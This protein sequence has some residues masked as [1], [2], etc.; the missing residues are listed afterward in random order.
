MRTGNALGWSAIGNVALLIWSRMLSGKV[1]Q[2][3]Q[4][5]RQLV[6]R[7]NELDASLMRYRDA[8]GAARQENVALRQELQSVKE[9]VTAR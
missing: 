7:C 1:D 4:D 6:S 5:N 3:T 8:L 2:L 9:Q